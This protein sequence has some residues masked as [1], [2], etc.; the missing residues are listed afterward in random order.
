MGSLIFLCILLAFSIVNVSAGAYD[1]IAY[2]T[3]RLNGAKCYLKI[4]HQ[5]NVLYNLP[6][7][8]LFQCSIP[9]TATSYKLTIDSANQDGNMLSLK[10]NKG[11][12]AIPDASITTPADTD[13]KMR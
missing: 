3:V 6:D 12:E 13:G 7:I 1:P 5:G 9:T 10:A 4:T 11:L 2:P 8:L